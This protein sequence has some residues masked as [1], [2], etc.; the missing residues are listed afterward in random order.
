MS[1]RIESIYLEEIAVRS[2]WR[3]ARSAVTDF[4]KTISA[5]ART[6]RHFLFPWNISGDNLLWIDALPAAPARSSGF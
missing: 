6:I 5:R 3:R 1:L 2:T 4:A